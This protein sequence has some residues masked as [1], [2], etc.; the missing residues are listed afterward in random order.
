VL[1][2]LT[3]ALQQ[4]EF[5]DWYPAGM[6]FVSASCDEKSHELAQAFGQSP[7]YLEHSLWQQPLAQYQ[8]WT[9][10]SNLCDNML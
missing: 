5:F 7:V 4:D 6:L 3:P 9:D 10:G 2:F 8:A 1:Q